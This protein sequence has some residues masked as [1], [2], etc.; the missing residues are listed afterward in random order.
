[1]GVK[2]KGDEEVG[3]REYA[4]ARH[5]GFKT[6]YISTEIPL[7]SKGAEIRGERDPEGTRTTRLSTKNF[8]HVLLPPSLHASAETR[9]RCAM[10]RMHDLIIY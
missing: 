8:A 5:I 3:E 1:M 2:V 6:L 10:V 7:V 9:M 4:R